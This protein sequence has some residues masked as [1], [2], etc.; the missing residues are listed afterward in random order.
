MSESPNTNI[1]LCSICLSPLVQSGKDLY[2]TTCQHQFHFECLTKNIQA[3]NNECPLC[4]TLLNSLVDVIHKPAQSPAPPVQVLIQTSPPSTTTGIWS[5]LRRSMINPY[6][7]IS[8]SSTPSRANIIESEDRVDEEAV[9]ALS[10]RMQAARRTSADATTELASVTATTTLE[11]GGQVLNQTSNIYG[12]VTLKAPSLLSQ[13][14]SEKQLNELRVPVDIVC[15]VDQS[16]SMQGEKMILLK[17]TL[18]YIIEQMSPLDR[19]AIISFDT[20][21]Y[22]RSNGLLMMTATK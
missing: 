8:G 13:A 15:V 20:K 12:M 5:T 11:F 18:D 9:R 1:D 21:A 19:L 7:W 22:N 16:G 6:N 4:R 17:E 14:A 3:Q 2:T 10:A